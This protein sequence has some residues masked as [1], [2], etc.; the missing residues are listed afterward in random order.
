MRRDV[1]KGGVETPSRPKSSVSLGLFILLAA[2]GAAAIGA[3]KTRKKNQWRNLCF[4]N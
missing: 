1:E 4:A 3:H 2:L